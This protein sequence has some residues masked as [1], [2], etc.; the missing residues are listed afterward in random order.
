VFEL[1]DRHTDDIIETMFSTLKSN[2]ALQVGALGGVL[3]A[4]IWAGSE[5]LTG[6]NPYVGAASGFS[7]GTG[8]GLWSQGFTKSGLGLVGLGGL[9]IG[10][11][12]L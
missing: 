5:S 6:N 12:Y 3:G 2:R 11:N 10:L 4:G 9:G 8:A 1:D 7:F